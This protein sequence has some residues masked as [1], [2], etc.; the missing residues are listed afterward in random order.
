MPIFMRIEGI[1]G[2]ATAAGYERW[3]EL[4]SYSWG[5][6]NASAALTGGGAGAG[7]VSMGDFFVMMPSGR[8]A[9]MLAYHCA[10]ARSLPAVQIHFANATGEGLEPYQRW[11]LENVRITSYQ[12]GASS[13]DL[14]TDSVSLNF[15]KIKFEQAVQT[16]TGGVRYQEFH[17]DL[18][19][20]SGGQTP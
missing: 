2:S 8:G 4:F 14:P 20:S 16:P 7:K 9:P 18:R 15:T 10:A 5:E 17:W 11:T 12:T 3:F 1:D 19:N 13:G 6:S